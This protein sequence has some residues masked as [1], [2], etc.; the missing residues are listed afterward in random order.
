MSDTDKSFLELCVDL[1]R[2]V[3]A[4]GT[5][6]TT[7]SSQ[8]GESARIVEWIRDA[9]T[10]I[11]NLHQDWNFLWGEKEFSTKTGGVKGTD[12]V[13]T[14][15]DLM[16]DGAVRYWKRDGLVYNPDSDNYWP[17]RFIEWR[18]WRQSHRLGTKPAG[19]PTQ[20][21]V[22]PNKAIEIDT[23]PS[24]AVTI[25]AEYGKALT[26]MSANDSTSAIP[27][28]HRRI[29]VLKA[30]MLY[31]EY[32]SAPEVYDSASSEY[33]RMLLNLEAEE[34][35]NREF[36]GTSEMSEPLVVEAV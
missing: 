1:R 34:L 3:G 33:D 21:T 26:R 22:R 11:Q 19:E 18:T 7:I 28:H 6:P 25:R 8:T 23:L 24:T 4:A 32:E 14:I 10:F 16:L 17:L 35:P 9:D 13:H 5:G 31:A 29:I 12:D 20:F 36:A 15:S 27:A 2:E 30:K